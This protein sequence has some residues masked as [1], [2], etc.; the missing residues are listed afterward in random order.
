MRMRKSASLIAEPSH[1]IVALS[2]NNGMLAS[3]DLA[4]KAKECI[5]ATC[6]VENGIFGAC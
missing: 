1:G 5:E 6:A 2:P 3:I 4:T